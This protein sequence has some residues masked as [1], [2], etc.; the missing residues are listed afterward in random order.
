[1][2]YLVEYIPGSYGEI[3]IDADWYVHGDV[4]IRDISVEYVCWDPWWNRL[5]RWLFGGF[6]K[7]LKL[8]K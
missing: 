4:V 1:M 5:F 3:E 2:R 8:K 6:Y 7:R